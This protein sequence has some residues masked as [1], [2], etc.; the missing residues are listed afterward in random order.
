M[1]KTAQRDRTVPQ[2]PG[3]HRPAL[4]LI[5]E[6]AHRIRV[7]AS[8]RADLHR[9]L[10]AR[11]ALEGKSVLEMIEEWIEGLPDIRL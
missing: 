7:N 5:E 9:K 6:E 8:V 3:A 4:H 11:A 10:K 2:V 1:K